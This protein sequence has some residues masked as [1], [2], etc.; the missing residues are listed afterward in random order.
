M[1]RPPLAVNVAV[2]DDEGRVLMTRREDFEVWCLP[3]GHL[4]EGE[5][6]GAAAI[7]EVR[8][9]TGLEVE[10]DRLVGLYSRPAWGSY[11]TLAVF[12]GHVVGGA[13]APDPH[14][15]VETG[16]FPLDQPPQPLLWGQAERLAD[17][18]TGVGGS[19]VRVLRGG[20]P[21]GWSTGRQEL[22]ERRDAS[23]LS[24]AD[25]YR[26]HASAYDA[27]PRGREV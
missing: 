9:E 21:D 14:E 4:E 22:Y 27:A 26:E 1:S 25:F 5:S 7:R 2:L 20:P 15:V 17:V 8:E 3:G 19:V 16:F 12:T 11:H 24:R 10:L 13:L 23:G 18:A 6:L